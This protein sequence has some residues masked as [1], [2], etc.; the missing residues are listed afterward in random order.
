VRARVAD[1]TELTEAQILAWA[2][3]HHQRTAHWPN[4]LSGPVFRVPSETW[5]RIDNALKCGRRGLPG[6]SSL[7]RL[8]LERRGVRHKG[9]LP[10]FTVRLL[11]QWAD[12]Y[13]ARTGRWPRVS[14]GPIPEAPGETWAIVNHALTTGLR[15]LPGG[16]SL[17]C[18]LQ[19]RRPARHWLHPPRVTEAQILAWADAH[20]VQTGE[21]P[22]QHSG[23][24]LG[25][26]GETWNCLNLALRL[27]YRG[28]PGGSSLA[29]L[30]QQ[31]RGGAERPE[32]ARLH[33]GADPGLGGGPPRA[34][35]PVAAGD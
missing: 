8:L 19:E 21:W 9:K 12:A 30:L 22:T 6:G 35:G 2:D 25:M 18:L 3:R 27:G 15:G 1:R 20:H 29:Q 14:S 13:H 33:R 28:L 26:P 11:L 7:A 10:R 31:A 24:V 23:P 4:R 32:L 5:P 34:H 17:A 16:S